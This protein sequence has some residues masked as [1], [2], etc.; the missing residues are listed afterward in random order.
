MVPIEIW[1]WSLS[2]SCA[3]IVR[4]Y[5]FEIVNIVNSI[6][7]LIGFKTSLPCLHTNMK[8]YWRR[9]LLI[10]LHQV[11]YLLRHLPQ[12]CGAVGWRRNQFQIWVFVCKDISEL[13][14]WF[15]RHPDLSA[16]N[17]PKRLV[18]GKR[19]LPVHRTPLLYWKHKLLRIHI[20]KHI[21]FIIISMYPR[22]RHWSFFVWI[23]DIE[24]DIVA[25]WK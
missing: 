1:M 12:G 24:T 17:A 5:L 7:F 23:V 22:K 6:S 19:R 4:S 25:S 13:T 16:R 20:I 9:D 2:V 8:W 15:N 21:T 18:P 11:S 3:W 10:Y 14:F